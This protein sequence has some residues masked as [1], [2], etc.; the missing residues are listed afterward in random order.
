MTGPLNTID[1]ALAE[2]EELFEPPTVSEPLPVTDPLNVQFL[3]KFSLRF[4]VNERSQSQV[5][6]TSTVKSP[7]TA[8][9]PPTKVNGFPLNVK[10]PTDTESTST[11]SVCP[12]ATGLI[13]TAAPASGTTPSVQF[14]A[15]DQLPF[16][17]VAPDAPNAKP[18]TKAQAIVFIQNLLMYHS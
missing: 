13:V 14:S 9:A 5:T 6:T 16:V 7:A 15:T 4:S 12:E 8:M 3:L 1:D 18:A 2:L 17:Q 11:V 10:P